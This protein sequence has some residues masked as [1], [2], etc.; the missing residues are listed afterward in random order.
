MN[1]PSRTTKRGRLDHV[2]YGDPSRPALT[3][4]HAGGLT[5]REWDH[6]GPRFGERYFVVAPTALGHGSSP[7]AA[8]LSFTDLAESVLEL[9]GDLGVEKTHVLGSS[10]GGATALY[11]ATRFPERIDRLV[12]YRTNFRT[13]PRGHAA[14]EAMTRAETWRQWGLE[15]QMREQHLPQGGPDAWV[16]V[17]K[18]VIAMVRSEKTGALAEPDDLT[19]VLAPTLLICGDRDPLVPLEEALLMYESIPDAALW[20]VP[21]ATHVLQVESLRRDSFPSEILAFLR[22]ERR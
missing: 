3:L 2:T 22:K 11:I 4:L 15:A 14:L 5:H 10:M 16:E 21:D 1:S 19:R 6:L 9:L 7:Q 13:G 12:L 18:K 20:V 8:T 17:T